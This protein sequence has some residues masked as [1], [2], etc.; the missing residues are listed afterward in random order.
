MSVL[1]LTL[2]LLCRSHILFLDPFCWILTSASYGEAA[3]VHAL[4]LA[5]GSCH[6]CL[7]VVSQRDARALRG[8]SFALYICISEVEI[9]F[10]PWKNT[11][12]EITWECWGTSTFLEMMF[13][14]FQGYA[15][16]GLHWSFDLC[17]R[18]SSLLH[19]GL[20]GHHS[21]GISNWKLAAALG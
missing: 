12:W 17:G 7:K 6:E 19:V 15:W 10:A 21:Y 20:L 14:S 16:F 3:M 13:S 18:I 8:R 1:D 5:F 11:A 9:S 2:Q 4:F